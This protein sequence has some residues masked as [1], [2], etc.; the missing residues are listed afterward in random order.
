M[1]VR[2]LTTDEALPD[3][4][5]APAPWA[6][7]GAGWILLMELPEAV[8]Q[9]T[10]HVPQPLRGLPLDGPSIVMFVDYADSPAGPYRELLYIPG[11]VQFPDGR[12]AWSVTRIYV[13]SWDSVVNGRSNWGI[14][15]DRADFDCD[16]SGRSERIR[17]TTGD[18]LI[19]SLELERRGPAWPVH[20]G[21]LPAAFRRVVQYHGGHRFELVPE[22]RGRAGLARLKNATSDHDLFPALDEGQVRMA[23][24]VPRFRLC[25]PPATISPA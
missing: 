19:A 23:L 5:R 24:H 21:L 10:R 22:A 18:R 3:V 1:S 15:K 16:S 17:V 13:S 25:F 8:R 20:A 14:P 4:P 11:R 6:L 2:L 9:D 12:R 7:Q